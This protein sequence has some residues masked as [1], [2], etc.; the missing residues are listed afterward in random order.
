MSK[1]NNMDEKIYSFTIVKGTQ[2]PSKHVNSWQGT[3]VFLPPG[4]IGETFLS[5]WTKHPKIVGGFFSPENIIKLKT[6]CM[7]VQVNVFAITFISSHYLC[8]F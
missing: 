8:C 6:N 7:T 2:V 1:Q 5:R 3:L 4:G